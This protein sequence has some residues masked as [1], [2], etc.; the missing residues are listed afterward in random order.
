MFTFP[1]ASICKVRIGRIDPQAP[2]GK[3]FTINGSAGITSLTSL[4]PNYYHQVLVS[5]FAAKE[6]DKNSHILPNKTLGYLYS[7]NMNNEF[8]N[9]YGTM[10]A[11]FFL[12]GSPV[13]YNCGKRKKLMAIIGG[14]TPHNSKQMPMILNIYKMPQ[15]SHG[16]FDPALSD[17]IQFPSLYLMIAN[18]SPQYAGIVQL[19]QHFGWTWIGLFVLD[20]DSGEMVLRILIPLLLENNICI[21][22]KEIIPTPKEVNGDTMQVDKKLDRIISV[23]SSTKINV[24]LVHGDSRSVDTLRLIL[25]LYENFEMRPIERVWIT[26]AHLDIVSAVHNALFPTKSLNGT[27][28]F[29]FHSNDLAEYKEYLEALNPKQFDLYYFHW[30]WSTAFWC[31]APKFEYYLPGGENC[32]GDEKLRSLPGSVFEMGMS[33]QSYSIYNAVYAVAHALHAMISSTSKQKRKGDGAS[34]NLSNIYPWQLHYF[35]KHIHFNNTAGEEIF[36]DQNGELATRYDIINIV[37]FPN[38]SIRKVSIGRMDPQAPEGKQFTINGSAIVWNHKFNQ[39]HSFLKHVRFN[40]SAGEEFF[41]DENGELTTGYDIINTVTFPNLSFHRVRVGWMDLRNP[42]G[43][44][45]TI[46]GSA[47]VWNHKFNQVGI[48]LISH[49]YGLKD[50]PKTKPGKVTCLLCQAVFGIIFSLAVSCVLAKTITVVLAFMATKPGNRMRKWVGKRLAVSVIIL[51]TL[52]QTGICVVWLATSPPF[53]EFDMHSQTDQIIVQCN[54]GSDILI[55]I[56]L[57]YMG[58]L[59]IISFTVA[60]FARKLPDTFNEAKLIT[61]SMLVFCSVWL[62]FVTSYLSMKGKYM[63]AM[64]IFS[65]LASSAGL[66]GCIFFPKFFIIVLRPELNTRDQLVRKKNCGV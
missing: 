30:F 40:N 52:S 31:K 6:I 21:A 45:F 36:F 28:S 4:L 27:L 3:Q 33:G 63:V 18:E 41:F 37:T 19:F 49:N 5:E 62:S 15:L 11:L 7:L 39:L 14:L 58:L 16:S 60:F 23:L 20:D 51:S 50:R 66:L 9:C 34:W 53:P 57:G 38:A 61:F 22:F 55:Y 1:N 17:K 29:T 8:G 54:E 42:K 10:D 26:T 25:A 43:K 64:E 46:N 13:N 48:T 2:E 59:A 44:Q 65:I 32:T 56:V 47:I 12:Q 35:L 24:F